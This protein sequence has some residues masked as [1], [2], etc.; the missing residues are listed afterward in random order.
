MVLQQ[1]DVVLR[2]LQL[3]FLNAEAGVSH[4]HRSAVVVT[5]KDVQA[6]LLKGPRVGLG[7]AL[8]GGSDESL[9]VEEATQP[10][11][12]GAKGTGAVAASGPT[13]Q[14]N[15][16][17]NK[18]ILAVLNCLDFLLIICSVCNTRLPIKW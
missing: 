14:H 16:Q 2:Y 9:R 13:L 18:G 12:V 7:H 11:G 17:I 1:H 4:A 10:D 15:E 8:P 3:E 5:D 6:E